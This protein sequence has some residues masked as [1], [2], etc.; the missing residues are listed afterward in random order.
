MK[1]DNYI[2]SGAAEHVPNSTSKDHGCYLLNSNGYIRAMSG[3]DLVR[4]SPNL[5]FYSNSIIEMTFKPFHK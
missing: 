4:S 3:P 1:E 2:F 5:R